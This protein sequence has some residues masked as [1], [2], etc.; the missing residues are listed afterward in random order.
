LSNLAIRVIVALVGIPLLIFFAIEGGVLFFVFVAVVSALALHEFYSLAR[1]KG[2]SP[3]MGWGLLFGFCVN[4]AFFHGKLQYALL[5]VL[6]ARGVEVPL[7]SMT[8]LLM[9]LYLLFVPAILLAEL[10]RNKP[11]AIMNAATTLLG[12]SYISLFLGTLIGV[13]ELFVPAD[14][15][16]YAHF[17]VSGASVAPEVEQTIYRWGGLTIIAIFASIWICDSAAYFAGRAMGRHKLFERVSPKKTWEGAIAGFIGAVLAFVAAKALVLPYLSYSSAL[18]CGGIVGIFGQ[19]GDLAESL[20]KRDA[21]VKDSSALI[22][23]HGGIF[24]RFDSLLFVSPLLY[25]YLDF[26][27]F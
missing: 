19:L 24:D 3:Q 13:R 10:F 6:V 26:I 7:P 21:G 16:V 11:Q 2:V 27:V 4:A 23:G 25:F 17:Q 22:P 5:G 18:I 12:V 15:P 1:A 14:F 8:Q 20:M 9:I